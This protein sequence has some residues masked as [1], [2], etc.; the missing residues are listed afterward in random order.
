[1]E[2]LI[3]VL[4]VAILATGAMTFYGNYRDRTAMAQ[5]ATNL[6]AIQV[7]A[8][9]FTRIHGRLPRTVAALLPDLNNDLTLITCPED[10]TPPPA[11]VSYA[12]D[13]TTLA[14]AAAHPG[15]ELAWMLDPANS[16]AALV[17]ESDVANGATV[18]AR[19]QGGSSMEIGITGTPHD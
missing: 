17:I 11:G 19:H 3:V 1:M 13:P 8:K 18:A 5:D 12:I 10:A 16:G 14:A 4:T 2:L 7:A 6:K 9:M 15:G